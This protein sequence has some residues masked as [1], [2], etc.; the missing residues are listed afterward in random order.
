MVRKN[1]AE[2]PLMRQFLEV[3]ADHPDAILFFRMGDF[4]EMFFDD[5][6]VAGR[7]LD[8]TITSRDKGRE[9]AIPMA[10]VP[11]HAGRGYLMRLTELG[12]KVVVVEQVEDPRQAKGLVRR[13]VVQI[14]TPGV[15]IDDDALDP[16]RARYLAAVVPAARGLGVAHLDASTGELRAAWVDGLDQ[17]AGELTRIGPRELLAAEAD[18]ADGGALAELRQRLAGCTFSPEEPPAADRIDELLAELATDGAEGGGGGGGGADG[19]GDGDAAARGRERELARRAAAW[20]VRYARATQPAGVLPVSRLQLY[21]IRD[22]VVLDEAAIINLE[23][24][25]TIMPGPGP[26]AGAAGGRRGG[27]LLAVL[28]RTVTAPGGR[29]LRHWLLYPL[30]DVAP[31]RRRQDAVE[32][33]V[34]RQ[35]ARDEVRR[36][37][38]RIHDLERLAGRASLGVATPRDMG[39]L[40][41]SLGRLPSLVEAIGAGAAPGFDVPELLRL[42]EGSRGEIL[43]QLAELEAELA[44]A[45]VDDPPPTAREG[46]L[47]RDG[48]CPVVDENRRLADGGRDAILAIEARERDRTSIP[49]LKVKY[50]RVFGYYIEVTRSQLG[51]VPADYV[52]KQT[53]ATGER[54]VT[55]ELAQLEARILA[56]Q[57]NLVAREAELFRA[58]LAQVARRTGALLAAAGQVAAIDV[59]AGLAELA[60]RSGYVRPLVDDGDAIDIAEGRHPVVERAVAAGAF[61]P[62]DCRL[63][64]GERQLLLLTGPNM[65]GKSTYM[66]QVAQIVLLAQLGSFVPARA[67]RVGVVDRIFTRVGAADNLARGES[68]F[69][70]EMRETAAILSGATRRSLVVLDEVGRGTSTFDGLSI[71]WAVAEY[72]HDRIGCR[73]LFATHYHEL[74]ALAESRPRVVN[75]QS[76]AREVEGRIAFLRLIIPGG[77]SRSYG[78]E[79]A[80]LAGLPAAVLS[81]SRQVLASLEGG[82]HLADD[83]GPQLGLFAAPPAAPPA[84]PEPFAARLRELDPDRMTPLEALALVAELCAAARRSAS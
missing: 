18:L 59:C 71:A 3:K 56:A 46:G 65:A 28:D 31:I 54:F 79:V 20:C 66:R 26:G 49:S 38:E 72:L 16:K 53:V 5:A 7:A 75:L 40:R 22:A 78:I 21:R 39:Q 57:E 13:E 81:R 74:C 76:A 2:T 33:F 6:L 51:R 24:T 15:V 37:L 29:L 1:P 17:L 60:H 80:R 36:E 84:P 77:A 67:A 50:N 58:L 83:S 43:A 10:G 4:Y 82:R 64:T 62:N 55:P 9:D 25:E 41:A 63:D 23:L 73:T 42:G 14:V 47:V 11:H 44:S 34:D 27:S 30:V 35:G 19:D 32:F 52:R 70:V 48:F 45:L 69:M 61:V 8:L 12:H 68:T